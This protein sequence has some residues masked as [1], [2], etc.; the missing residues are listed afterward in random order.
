MVKRL[1]VFVTV[2]LSIPAAVHAQTGSQIQP[3]VFNDGALARIRDGLAVSP[4]AMDARLFAETKN[5]VVR[6]QQP[7]AAEWQREFERTSALRRKSNNVMRLGLV[8]AGVGVL[9]AAA[10]PSAKGPMAIAMATPGLGIATWGYLARRKGDRELKRLESTRPAGAR[11]SGG[12]GT[13]Q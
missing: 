12:E 5:S 10:T 13:T 2:L 3:A 4:D 9:S 7:S 1:A 11:T 6:L 8:L